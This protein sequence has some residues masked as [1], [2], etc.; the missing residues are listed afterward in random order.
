MGDLGTPRMPPTYTT[1][2][3][4]IESSV[5]SHQPGKIHT[6]P[7]G[8]LGT[9]RMPPTYTTVKII[10]E[11]SVL[12]HQPGMIQT[13]FMGHPKRP[14]C[15]IPT[16]R[17][18]R[19]CSCHRPAG[20]AGP[21]RGQGGRGLSRTILAPWREREQV[22]PL[23]DSSSGCGTACATGR[24]RSCGEAIFRY[25]PRTAPEDGQAETT[26]HLAP[27]VGWDEGLDVSVAAAL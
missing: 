26:R 7:M 8:D 23:P 11:S 20:P 14:E 15:P 10:I 2:K 13:F 4:L 9:P 3:I 12:S 27:R 25:A 1:A 19:S 17:A 5:L 22:R 6:H 16:P 24:A 18:A 21:P